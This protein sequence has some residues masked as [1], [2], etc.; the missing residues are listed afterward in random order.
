[1]VANYI[2]TTIPI[3]L[4]VVYQNKNHVLPTAQDSRFIIPGQFTE[5]TIL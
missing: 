3:F 4:R 5:L 2:E 1:M